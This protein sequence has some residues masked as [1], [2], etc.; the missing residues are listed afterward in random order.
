VTLETPA[1]TF[2]LSSYGGTL[3]RARLREEKFFLK[4]G[5]PSSGINVVPTAEPETAPLRVTFPESDFELPEAGV[6]H[7]ERPA[8]DTVVFRT[9]TDA[10]RVE[11]RYKADPARYRLRLDVQVEN[12][13]A[14]SQDHHLAIHMFAR[15]DP[16]K[17]GG[18]FLTAA[19]DSIAQVVCHVNEKAERRSVEDLA[20]EPLDKV[21]AVRWLGADEKFFLVAAVPHPETPP[22][23]RTCA[24]RTRTVDTAAGALTF[25]ERTVP[26]GANTAY[27][28][29]VFA[30]PKVISELDDVQPGGQDARLGE[31]VDVT[32]AVISRP[33]LSLLKL[34]Y[35]FAGNWGL[36]II[37]LTVFVKAV[38][39][40]P[41]QRALMSAK[42][43][44]RLAPKLSAIRRK[45]ENDRQRQGAET[46]NLY[47]SHGVNPFGG[48]LPSLIQMP[49][50]IALY[51]TLMYAVELHRSAFFGHIQDL[52]AKDPYFITPLVMGAVMYVQMKMSPAS[53][54]NQQQKMMQIM[55]PV[56]FTGFSLVLPSGLAVYMLTSYLIGI[57]QQLLVNHLDRKAHGTMPAA[58]P[59][60]R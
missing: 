26:P 51:S 41:T 2:E 60:A 42:R 34:F 9:E 50:W 53:P 10:V 58:E 47:K 37:L 38:T 55:M 30:G 12:R 57:L 56:M 46:M 7:V 33:L 45:F 24:A 36:A 48:C 11:K 13:S 44:Q 19:S 28:V 3:R 5:D 59:A 40:Y 27:A 1:V 15:Q 18:S 35:R 54:D 6:W 16:G 39:F 43:M 49:I 31:A 8:P 25:A 32:L 52:T 21:G 17:K 22:R 14:K 23:E 20:K 29:T 4:K